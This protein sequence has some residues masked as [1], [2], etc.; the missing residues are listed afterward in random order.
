[1]RLG[2][3]TILSL[4]SRKHFIF[5]IIN[6]FL[7]SSM[8]VSILYNFKYM[9]MNV[10]MDILYIHNKHTECK[11]GMLLIFLQPFYSSHFTQPWWS[12]PREQ[13]FLPDE[14]HLVLAS[15]VILHDLLPYLLSSPACFGTMLNHGENRS[16]LVS[17][18][19]K[20]T[21]AVFA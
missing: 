3:S 16:I 19:L 4:T 2:I 8:N 21:A 20:A 6:V 15:L 9:C 5:L 18:Y 17:S 11:K 14:C 12:F 1:M 7:C 13:A 10:W